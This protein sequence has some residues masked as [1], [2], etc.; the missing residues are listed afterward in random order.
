MKTPIIDLF[1]GPGGLGEGLSSYKHNNKNPFKIVLSIEKDPYAHQTLELR[2]FIRQFPDNE[3]PAEYYL[4]I[5]GKI[6]REELLKRYPKQ[7]KTAKIEAWCAELGK[8][9]HCEVDDRIKKALKY[10]KKWMLIGGPPCQ[11]YSLAGRAR[12]KSANPEKFEKDHRHFLYKEYLRIIG[13]HKPP[14]FIM[15]NVKGILSSEIKGKKIFHR[16]LSDLQNPL[17]GASREKIKYNIYPLVKTKTNCP[18][19]FI[20]MSEKHGIP[21]R[22]HRVIVIGIRS[23]I[24]IIPE[25]LRKHEQEIPLKSV[26]C[27][28]PRIR[29]GI[30]KENDSFIN[31]HKALF[32]TKKENWYYSLEPKIKKEINKTLEKIKKMDRGKEYYCKKKKRLKYQKEWFIDNR[33]QGVCNYTSKMHIKEDL[34]RYLFASCFAKVNKRSPQISD[35]PKSLLPKHKNIKQAMNGSMFAD[36]FRVQLRNSPATTITSHISK[37]GHYFIHPD[38]TQCR[39]LTVREAA[40]VQTFPDNYFFEGRRTQQYMQVGNA[41]PPLLAK[42]IAEIAYNIFKK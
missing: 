13:K 15:E 18:S 24:E 31:W 35:F 29:S 21:Q 25:K 11:A 39:S 5:S 6:T 8:R 4:Y 7:R 14:V 17:N 9:K 3:L 22:R 42:Q 38:P 30:T 26:I 23:D 20:I 2:S 19:D 27:D 32:S 36:R 1:A 10:Q 28:L 34:H 40:R 37:D 41:V 16:I 12:M 33:L